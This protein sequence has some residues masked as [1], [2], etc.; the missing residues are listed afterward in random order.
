MRGSRSESGWWVGCWLAGEASRILGKER[1]EEGIEKGWGWREA[2]RG[3]VPSCWKQTKILSLHELKF[4]YQ[5]LANQSQGFQ[6]G[7][8]D[9][10]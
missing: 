8:H 2:G 4:L 5:S 7:S 9:K 3:P 6:V 10:R 1:W